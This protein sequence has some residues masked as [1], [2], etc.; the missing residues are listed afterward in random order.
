MVDVG[1]GS[2]AFTRVVADKL[3]KSR[4]GKIIGVDRDRGLLTIATRIAAEK[5]LSEEALFM[6]ADATTCIPLPDEFADRVVCQATLWMMTETER[7][8][9][10][11]EMIRICKKGGVVAA[12]EGAKD[13]AIN[14]VPFNPLLTQVMHKQ[15][16]ALLEGYPKARGWDLQIGYKLP[17]IFRQ[18]GLS[19]V[20]LD[21]VA[22]VHLASDTRY[23]PDFAEEAYE[24]YLRRQ[25]KLLSLV[26]EIETPEGKMK[27]I[28]KN[29]PILTAGGMGWEAVI[30]MA[31]LQVTYFSNLV[32]NP[33]VGSESATVGA[34]IRFV[35]SGVKRDRPL[36]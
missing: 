21:G 26:G 7:V 17:F 32:E 23:S 8:D 4:G 9:T 30:Q 29:E 6:S 10:L 3:D 1:C 34:S 31:E 33:R 13:T 36:W 2:G 15:S 22:D 18:L 5:G 20:R 27:F 24:F 19:D 16:Q 14:Y 12:V 11:K 25:K 35:T 28:E